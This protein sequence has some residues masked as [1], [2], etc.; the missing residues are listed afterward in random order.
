MAMTDAYYE[1]A[2]DAAP[3]SQ[4]SKRTYH[5]HLRVLRAL[6]GKDIDYIVRHPKPM[7]AAIY[8]KTSEVLSRKSYINSVTTL[9]RHVPELAEKYSV[10]AAAWRA[11]QA[12]ELAAAAKRYDSNE[13]TDRQRAAHVPWADVL[14]AR[15]ALPKDGND[16]L[17]LCMFTKIPPLRADFDR[18]AIVHKKLTAAQVA[19]E[20]NYLLVSPNPGADGVPS[21]TLVLNEFKSKGARLQQYHK[22]L[23]P[24]LCAVVHAS[25]ER[26]PRPYL[27][28]RPS[29]GE[30]FTSP[31]AYSLFANRILKRVFAPKPVNINTLRHSFV[32][33]LP[34]R[35]RVAA[36][37]AIARD[38][39]HSP[40]MQERYKLY[41]DDDGHAASTADLEHMR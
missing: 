30:R 17:L 24:D 39:L 3:L 22:E 12:V 11:A 25:L 21:M 32:S 14:K 6:T 2:L 38:M 33:A 1:A 26:Q 13:P 8:Q 35:L 16:Y 5:G 19:T 40:A 27:F 18:L 9:F 7:L 4:A 10:Q 28:V 23:P 20:P 36:K 29:T 41:F 15:D 37:D 31:S 34:D